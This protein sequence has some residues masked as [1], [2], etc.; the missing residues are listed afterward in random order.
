[1][2][3]QSRNRRIAVVLLVLLALLLLGWRSCSSESPSEPGRVEGT[4]GKE[5]ASSDA[6]RPSEAAPEAEER[7]TPATLSAPATVLAGATF[8]VTWTGP[9]NLGDFVALMPGAAPEV[10][11]DKLLTY[12][13]TSGGPSLEL[14]APVEPGAYELRYVTGR[15]RR[16]LGRAPIEVQA[17][18]VTLEAPDEVV[19]G[20]EVSVRWTGP[21]HAGDYITLVAKGT[22]DGQYANYTETSAGSPLTVLAP[23]TTGDHE[24]RYVAGQGPHDEV[25]A[26]RAVKVVMAAVELSAPDTAPAGST[27]QVTWTGPDNTGDYIT[28]VAVGTPDGTYDNYTNTQKGSPLPL[29]MPVLVGKAELR[30]VTGQ[31]HRVLARRAI[32]LRAPEVTLTAQEEAKAGASVSIHWTGPNYSG[33]Y[34]TIVAKDA[35]DGK[36]G[37]YQNTSVGSPL[38]VAAP[39]SPGLSEIRYVTGQGGKVL[40][41]RDL[42]I[43]P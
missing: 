23:T 18:R 37:A 31:G 1:M 34:L 39:K 25:L 10:P 38:T 35:A 26:R 17:A 33:D 36:F 28:V 5:P 42:R 30:Y 41:R 2:S 9:D 29:L 16:V 32:D 21:G 22:P 14:V 6:G 3:P 8:A 4:T 15:A 43:T 40:A 11:A 20:A 7:F 27:V 13:Q 24:L 19:L 12:A